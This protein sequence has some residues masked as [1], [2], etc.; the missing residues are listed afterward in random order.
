[1]IH[2]S[3]LYETIWLHKVELTKLRTT[4]LLVKEILKNKS[5]QIIILTITL[6][7]MIDKLKI[8]NRPFHKYVLFPH[9]KY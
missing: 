7:Q 1:M 4:T 9:T 3:E 8:R 6:I 5:F 2:L